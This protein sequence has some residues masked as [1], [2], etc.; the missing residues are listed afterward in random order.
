MT[1]HH[2]KP[3]VA[4]AAPE[5]SSRL[6][7]PRSTA[8][9]E[10]AGGDGSAPPA[11]PETKEEREEKLGWILHDARGSLM[12]IGAGLQCLAHPQALEED[13]ARL[14]TSMGVALRRVNLLLSEIGVDDEPPS[15]HSPVDLAETVREVAC[16]LTPEVRLAGSSLELDVADPVCGHWQPLWLWKIAHNLMR[17]AVVHGVGPVVVQLS[18]RDDVAQLTVRDQGPGIPL[19][20][21]A[22]LFESDRATDPGGGSRRRIGLWVVRRCVED[23]GGSLAIRTGI[24]A[25]SEVC[26]ELPGARVGP[27]IAAG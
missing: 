19:E 7:R 5:S 21:Y 27:G 24:A 14:L 8:A 20:R 22:A 13:R 17:N 3:D 15:R 26:V 11:E 23:L 25:G 18:R 10:H 9:S 4:D 2:Q 6:G 16:G 1:S 12:A